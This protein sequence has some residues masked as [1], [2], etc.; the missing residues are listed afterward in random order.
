MVSKALFLSCKVCAIHSDPVVFTQIAGSLVIDR[1]L[2]IALAGVDLG[3]A[4]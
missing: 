4:L 1:T 2:V 3:S